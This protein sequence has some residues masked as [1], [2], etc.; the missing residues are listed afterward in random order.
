MCFFCYKTTTKYLSVI[1][2]TEPHHYLGMLQ[3]QTET[4]TWGRPLPSMNEKKL[5]KNARHAQWRPL[6]SIGQN[7]FS[8]N[9]NICSIF[10]FCSSFFLGRIRPLH[11]QV[12]S[13]QVHS[14]LIQ[15]NLVQ[16][17]QSHSLQKRTEYYLFVLIMSLYQQYQP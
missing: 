8:R 17:H 7:I 3:K 11:A 10:Y 5:Q 4:A 2:T 6:Y 12:Q 15:F 14:C 13:I 16:S 9:I 1:C